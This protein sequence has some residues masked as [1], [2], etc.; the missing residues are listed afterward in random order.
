MISDS[1]LER[2]LKALEARMNSSEHRSQS[3]GGPLH[4]VVIT[5][6]WPFE[7][8]FAVAGQHGFLRNPDD[9]LDEF[10]DR[11]AQ[12]ARAHGE[13]LLVVGG[14]PDRQEHQSAVIAEYDRW[15]LTDDGVPPCEPSRGAA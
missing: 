2:R 8:V 15:L 10:A 3:S 13:P 14:L 1:E 11:C 6:V 7:P 9:S 12:E 4:V 5:G